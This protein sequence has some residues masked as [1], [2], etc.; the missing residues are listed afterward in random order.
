MLFQITKEVVGA[1][2]NG[3]LEKLCLGI[4]ETIQNTSRS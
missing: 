4:I 3:F 2:L 1:Q